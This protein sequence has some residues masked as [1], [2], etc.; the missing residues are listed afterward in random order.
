[1]R[2]ILMFVLV[3]TSLAFSNAYAEVPDAVRANRSAVVTIYIY[4]NNKQVASGSGFI[5]DASGKVVTNAHVVSE[6]N[7]GKERTLLVKMDN[8][9]WL[10]P[11]DFLASD[12]DMDVAI[13]SVSARNLPFVRLARN[14]VPKEGEDIYVIGSPMGLE[15]SFSSGIISGVRGSDS[16]LQLTAPISPGSSGSPV[17]NAA[18]E[19]IG[20]ATMIIK[21]S[22]NLNF[23][24]AY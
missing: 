17:F 3:V 20:V 2:K 22:Q 19:V 15:T 12:A 6:L 24:V 23:A 21:E 11:G 8:G 18:G 1:M 13:F 4:E 5:M 9:S 7:K 14:Y 10:M 16:F